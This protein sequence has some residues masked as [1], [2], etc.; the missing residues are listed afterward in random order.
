[1]SLCVFSKRRFQESYKGID[2]YEKVDLVGGSHYYLELTTT[3]K[4][5]IM[6]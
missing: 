4:A 6:V 1:V 5:A 3:V 2:I